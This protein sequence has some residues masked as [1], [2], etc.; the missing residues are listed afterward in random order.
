MPKHIMQKR[1]FA[2]AKGPMRIFVDR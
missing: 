2:A 1:F